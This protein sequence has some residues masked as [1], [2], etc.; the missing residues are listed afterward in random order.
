MGG[1]GEMGSQGR[2]RVGIAHMA[3]F[4]A[5]RSRV[6][7]AH[8]AYFSAIRGRGGRGDRRA[9]E[10][11]E[12]GRQGRSRV[13][14]AHMAYFSAI[15]GRGDRGGLRKRWGRWGKDVLC[16]VDGGMRWYLAANLF[17]LNLLLLGNAKCKIHCSKWVLH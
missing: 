11:G 9:G 1:M 12:R 4:S 2:S 17:A 16:L 3:Y 15:R 10:M 14:I 7:I 8:M 5:I 13:G 6:D